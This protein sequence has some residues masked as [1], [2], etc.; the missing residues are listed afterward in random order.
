MKELIDIIHVVE[1][2]GFGV[3]VTT[4]IISTVIIC[5]DITVSVQIKSAGS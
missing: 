4:H 5:Y 3:N 1:Y 2:M